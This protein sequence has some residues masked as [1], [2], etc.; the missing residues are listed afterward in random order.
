MNAKQLLET[1]LE[2]QALEIAE[3]KLDEAETKKV[4]LKIAELRLTLPLG[5]LNHYD[6]LRM[7]G[8]RCVAQ[9]N[10]QTCSGCHVRVTKATVMSLMH[11]E[12]IQICENCGRYLYLPK[13]T[14]S[15]LQ[16]SKLP[17]KPAKNLPEL[18]NL[19]HAA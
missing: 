11:G 19:P 12:D 15:E 3:A 1:L 6:R 17:K 2:I 10:N 13:P 16:A 7:R 5:M 8:K 4:E 9:V 14:E 18:E